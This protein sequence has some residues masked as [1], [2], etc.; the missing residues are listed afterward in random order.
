AP[1]HGSRTSSTGAFLDAVQ[2][3]TAVFQAGY[4]NRFGHPAP[5]VLERYRERGTRLRMSPAC[6]AWR[7]QSEG[8]AE[9]V[10][11][12]D[13]VRRYWHHRPAW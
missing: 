7:W 10:C 5:D 2:P 4:R 11:Q 8:S 9:G 13:A 3:T 1:H 6:G 12:R